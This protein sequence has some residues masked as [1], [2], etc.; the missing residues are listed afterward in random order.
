MCGGFHTQWNKLAADRCNLRSEETHVLHTPPNI[1][2]GKR[3]V[4]VG[5]ERSA[6]K[7]LVR[8]LKKKITVK[9]KRRRDQQIYNRS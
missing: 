8:K 5:K 3:M 1:I 7:I 9:F 4:R 6:Y 2:K